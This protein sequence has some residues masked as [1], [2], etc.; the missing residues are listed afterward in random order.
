MAS[1]SIG[2]W[3]GVTCPRNE[4]S[5]RV[6]VKL[7]AEWFERSISSDESVGYCGVVG[8]GGGRGGDKAVVRLGL[9][10]EEELEAYLEAASPTSGSPLRW[11]C[12]TRRTMASCES[13][14]N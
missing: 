3:S 10:E 5:E 8:G 1:K 11:N 2:C 12:P 13:V 9:E 7:G 14:S 6:N 4:S